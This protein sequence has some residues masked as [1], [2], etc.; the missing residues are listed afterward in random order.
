MVCETADCTLHSDEY[1]N[2]LIQL[3]LL[4]LIEFQLYTYAIYYIY[5]HI[6]LFNLTH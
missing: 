6:Y 4:E 2:R 1:F 5:R 3:D